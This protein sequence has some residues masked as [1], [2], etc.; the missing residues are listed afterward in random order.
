M[1]EVYYNR[2]NQFIPESQAYAFRY[3]QVRTN[4][5]VRLISFALSTGGNNLAFNTAIKDKGYLP[6]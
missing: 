4:C 2:L 3:E 5:F 6:T 1:L